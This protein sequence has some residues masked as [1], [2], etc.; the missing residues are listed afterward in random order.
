MV[1]MQIDWRAKKRFVLWRFLCMYNRKQWMKSPSVCSIL[2]RTPSLHKFWYLYQFI[3]EIG[4]KWKWK[5]VKAN[6][7]GN[8]YASFS[9]AV[10]NMKNTKVAGT[11][12]G[13]YW[14]EKGRKVFSCLLCMVLYNELNW[15]E[16][17]IATPE[18]T[19]PV[20]N[21]VLCV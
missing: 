3:I 6:F 19:T 16:T 8:L 20:L 15:R 17:Y 5:W 9:F 11:S 4:T 2:D 1:S 7:S 10:L 13:D 21:L 14:Q 12:T 18:I